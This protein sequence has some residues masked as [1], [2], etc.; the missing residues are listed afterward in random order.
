MGYNI[1]GIIIDSLS[2]E[3]AKSELDQKK[4]KTKFSKSLINSLSPKDLSITFL[5]GKS[6]IFLDQIFVKNISEDSELTNLEND[7]NDIFPDSRILIVVINDTVNF[8][9]YSYIEN[10]IK[11]R[12]KAVVGDQEFLDFGDLNKL[13]KEMLEDIKNVLKDHPFRVTMINTVVGD[14]KGLE[15]DKYYLKYRDTMF[16]KQ[17][18]E[19]NYFYLDGTADSK[20]IEELW[21]DIIGC[22]YHE[23]EAL[24]WTVFERRRLNF[25]KDSPKDYVCL[26][27]TT[28]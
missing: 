25:K 6:L 9:G 4:Q 17:K 23:L 1:C 12:T 5:N 7:L 28:N 20:I 15:L 16:K 14:M 26:S 18:I 27:T 10:G 13:E 24:S 21:F 8:T 19:R 3:F 11:Q 2:R 22:E